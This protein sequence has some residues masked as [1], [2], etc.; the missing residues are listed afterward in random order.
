MARTSRLRT[1]RNQSEYWREW[2]SMWDALPVNGFIHA[3]KRPDFMVYSN[4]SPGCYR[5]V[6]YAKAAATRFSGLLKKR[7]V[8]VSATE[9]G[10]IFQRIE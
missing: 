5:S 2:R 10:Y 6:I 9:R 1:I 3:H 4:T 8:L 7:F